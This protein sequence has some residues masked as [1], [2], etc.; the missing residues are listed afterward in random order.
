MELLFELILELVMEGSI[1]ASRSKAVPKPVRIV[2]AALVV[3]FFL[4]AIGLIVFAGILMIRDGN[5]LAGAF[6]FLLAAL[7]LALS[8]R[9]FIRT[10][11]K[12]AK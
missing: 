12:K 6:M 9:G 1:E 7:L 8:I 10:Y 5:T 4:A 2:L 11:L 3:L